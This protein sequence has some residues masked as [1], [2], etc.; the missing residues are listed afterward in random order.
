MLLLPLGAGDTQ[1]YDAARV[2]DE[3]GKGVV[4]SRMVSA[5]GG[6]PVPPAVDAE[7]EELMADQAR[8]KD[9]DR[10]MLWRKLQA[11]IAK[12]AAFATE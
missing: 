12:T 6:K 8:K 5:D 7:L 11:E 1:E 2:A 3:L 4:E 9:A 10:V